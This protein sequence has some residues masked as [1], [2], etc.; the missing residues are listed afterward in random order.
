MTKINGVISRIERGLNRAFLDTVVI[1]LITAD[2]YQ[3]FSL[4]KTRMSLNFYRVIKDKKWVKGGI[5]D[6]VVTFFVG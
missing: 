4:Q 5:L 1:I 3:N 6:A 2:F